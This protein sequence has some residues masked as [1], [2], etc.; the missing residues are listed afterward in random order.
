MLH[1]VHLSVCYQ[2]IT[3]LLI[4]FK[5]NKI[6]AYLCCFEIKYCNL[7]KILRGRE[8]INWKALLCGQIWFYILVHFF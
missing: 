3:N 2:L 1:L 4:I 7:M 8:V 5:F 6:L